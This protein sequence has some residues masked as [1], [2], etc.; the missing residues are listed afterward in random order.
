MST[1]TNK[2]RWGISVLVGI[3]S[4]S[5]GF[6]FGYLL[7]APEESE[8]PDKNVSVKDCV[9]DANETFVISRDEM[10]LYLDIDEENVY[11]VN[12]VGDTIIVAYSNYNIE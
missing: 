7:F 1:K 9:V 10:S 11:Y 4:I 8:K 5:I 6:L 3:V 12:S 2:K